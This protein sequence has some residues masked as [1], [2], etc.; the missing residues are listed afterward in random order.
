MPRGW[1]QRRW[2][3]RIYSRG[4]GGQTPLEVRHM[5]TIINFWM[6]MHELRKLM[7]FGS[8][9]V[10]KG[11]EEVVEI[12]MCNQ[13]QQLSLGAIC[14]R[15][16]EWDVSLKI[17]HCRK[18]RLMWLMLFC[19]NLVGLYAEVKLNVSDEKWNNLNQN[20][21]WRCRIITS[22]HI[23]SFLKFCFIDY[24]GSCLHLNKSH[25][26]RTSLN[27]L[28]IIFDFVRVPTQLVCNFQRHCAQIPAP[29]RRSKTGGCCAGTWQT[30]RHKLPI[31]CTI[32][33]W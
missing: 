26:L 25:K 33:K 31:K 20:M 4:V 12:K 2:P 24:H 9:V 28:F 15:W 7:L 21:V 3:Y 22:I 30:P 5:E 14:N 23:P 10:K 11:T 29:C 27:F 6:H 16:Q 13:H 32:P 8:C 1:R 19:K 17:P 18:L